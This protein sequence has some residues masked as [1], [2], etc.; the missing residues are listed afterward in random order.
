[1]NLKK[2]SKN[3]KPGTNEFE[4]RK[5]ETIESG[6]TRDPEEF[7]PEEGATYEKKPNS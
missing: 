6:P 5:I 1:M 2:K 7:I 4:A 3:F